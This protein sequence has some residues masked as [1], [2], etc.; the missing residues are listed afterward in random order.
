V[1][2]TFKKL[3]AAMAA[4]PEFAKQSKAPPSE[5]PVDPKSAAEAKSF[6]GFIGTYVVLFQEIEAKL[7]QII[8]MALGRERSHIGEYVAS[9]LSLPFSRTP[10][11]ST[12]YKLS[13][14]RRQSRT[15]IRS[16]P[17]G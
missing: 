12:S 8:T 14:S 13:S 5:S 1:V 3:M 7:D 17:S 2:V 16:A 11:R 15:V 6:F 4:D 10:R 9:I